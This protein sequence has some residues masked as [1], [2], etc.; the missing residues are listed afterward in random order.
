[1]C[2]SRFASSFPQNSGLA[3]FFLSLCTTLEDRV[4]QACEL[5]WLYTLLV[6]SIEIYFSIHLFISIEDES[7]C[8]TAHGQRASSE[9]KGEE[10]REGKTFWKRSYTVGGSEGINP[11]RGS[12]ALSQDAITTGNTNLLVYINLATPF[13][14]SHILRAG[15]SGEGLSHT[16]SSLMED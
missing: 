6:M 1:M 4:A 14:F 5:S 12:L 8:L 11:S 15:R 9:G 10:G 16:P 3:H 7:G 13:S 2:L